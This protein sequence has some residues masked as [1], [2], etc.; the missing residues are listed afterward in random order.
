MT[1]NRFMQGDKVSY[2]GTKHA[3]ELHGK[4]GYIVGRV[5]NADHEVCVDFGEDAYVMDER[6]HLSRFQG[7]EKTDGHHDPKGPAVE[8]R[9]GVGGG[10]KRVVDQEAGE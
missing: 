10:R 3:K 6:H 2:V 4:L 1:N 5:Q 7:K 9:K 8:K